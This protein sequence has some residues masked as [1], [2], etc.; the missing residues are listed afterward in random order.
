[1][2]G[3]QL[4]EAAKHMKPIILITACNQHRNRAD[5]CRA[6]WLNTFGNLCDYRFIFG[7]GNTV[8][9]DDELVFEC[10]DT[11]FGLPKKVQ[12]SHQWALQQGYDYILKTDCDVYL[13]T[14]RVLVFGIDK[15]DYVG[16]FYYDTFAMGAAYWLSKKATEILVN[17]PL[18]APFAPG[19]DDVWVGKI[20]EQAGVSRHHEPR[21]YIGENP[22]YDSCFS[23]HV[24][25]PPKLDMFEVHRKMT[26]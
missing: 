20:M 24:S 19:G 5:M 8:Q 22:D 1:M 15:A 26:E 4:R 10:D 18:P 17:A 6:T 7:I 14:P 23:L 12:L 25:G 9:H 16:N 11:Y 13:H 2:A 3:M 21:Y